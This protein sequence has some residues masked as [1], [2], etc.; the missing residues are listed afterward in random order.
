[1][2]NIRPCLLWPDEQNFA[3]F[4]EIC[5]GLKYETLEAYLVP[6]NR[7]VAEQ[8]RLGIPVTKVAFD[9]EELLAFAKARGL[10][11]VDS[12]TRVLFAGMKA[13]DRH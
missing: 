9:P 11:R 4:S 3:R 10:D 2:N 5:G 8:E 13:D 1:M 6:L 7:Y 12:E